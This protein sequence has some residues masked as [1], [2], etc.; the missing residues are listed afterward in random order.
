MVM[1]K[2]NIF[3]I[4]A[5]L[6]AYVDRAVRGERIVICRHNTPVA[7][8]RA[9][10][11]VRTEPRPVGPLPGRPVFDLPRSFF[12]PLSD[13]ELDRWEGLHPDSG[14]VGDALRPGAGKVTERKRGYR[15][16]A[17]RQPRKRRS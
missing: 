8:L 1:L 5:K 16:R 17:P 3:E 4:K 2:V 7:E 15:A 13:D 9:I 12:E 6:S 10:E 14:S 11:A